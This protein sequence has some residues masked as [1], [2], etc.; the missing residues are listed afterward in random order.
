MRTLNLPSRIIR[1]LKNSVLLNFNID[2]L[3]NIK[4]TE[5]SDIEKIG[6]D[7]GG[8]Y[9]PTSLLDSDSI[10]YC[11]GCGEDISFDLG[12]I[13][14]IWLSCLWLRSYSKSDQTC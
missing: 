6:T 8:W 2:E 9:I 13:V 5:P 1:K 14:K 7:Y 3:T 10:C 4:F 12:L 11:V